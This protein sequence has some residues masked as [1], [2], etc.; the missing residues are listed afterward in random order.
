MNKGEEIKGIC[1]TAKEGNDEERIMRMI[2]EVSP[3]T[4]CFSFREVLKNASLLSQ[5]DFI[6]TYGG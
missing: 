3:E 1:V 6:F 2:K 4:K 5:I